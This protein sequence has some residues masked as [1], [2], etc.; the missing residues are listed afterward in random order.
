MKPEGPHQKRRNREPDMS[1]G[2]KGTAHTPAFSGE[3][4]ELMRPMVEHSSDIM[5]LLEEDGTIRYVSPAVERVLGF[6]P[7]EVVGTAVF[8]YV[9]PDDVEHALL[10]FS[11]VLQNTEGELPP[12]EFRARVVDGSWRHVE[13]LRNNRLD[14]PHVGGVVISVRDITRRKQ[15]EEAL[16][17]AEERYRT[18]VERLPAVTFVDR[19]GGSEESLYVSPQIEGML[20]YTPEEWIAGRRKNIREPHLPLDP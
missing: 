8:N 7:E 14:D 6:L 12:V 17:G 16:Q 11:E 13:V 15:A 3:N 5:A 18:L 19:A 4:E 2:A 1:A 10:A 20:G 9:H